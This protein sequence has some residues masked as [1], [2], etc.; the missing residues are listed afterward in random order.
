MGSAR[1]CDSADKLYDN[2]EMRDRRDKERSS[3]AD[4]LFRASTPSTLSAPS[5][6]LMGEYYAGASDERVGRWVLGR[7]PSTPERGLGHYDRALL[8]MTP[9]TPDRDLIHVEVALSG[10]SPSTSE[11][12]D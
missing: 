7:A 3:Q 2:A 8:G 11:E 10:I 9:S 4:R 1:D 12:E 5:T 6:L